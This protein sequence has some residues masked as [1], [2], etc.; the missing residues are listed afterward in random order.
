MKE[1]YGIHLMY[2]YLGDENIPYLAQNSSN[3]TEV[4]VSVLYTVILLLEND[5]L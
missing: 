5:V 3:C 4:P 1:Y 2:Q